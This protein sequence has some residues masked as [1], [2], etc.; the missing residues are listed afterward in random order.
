[1]QRSAELVRLDGGGVL[2]RLVPT[3][4]RSPTRP[5]S[6]EVCTRR[7]ATSATTNF[8]STRATSA[9]DLRRARRH[10]DSGSCSPRYDVRVERGV[11]RSDARCVVLP[12]VSIVA[13]CRVQH[14]A[15]DDPTARRSHAEKV[16]MSCRPSAT[17]AAGK[18]RADRRCAS[19]YATRDLCR[20]SARDCPHP[21]FRYEHRVRC[22][23]QP[24]TTD[25]PSTTRSSRFWIS[26]Q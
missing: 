18:H 21:Q 22:V 5:T 13:A 3:V 11:D 7:S 14:R 10:D 15:S 17:R 16:A 24:T 9:R 6:V 20:A 2:P 26:P 23:M 12:D 4:R 1:M 25:L 19:I 8:S